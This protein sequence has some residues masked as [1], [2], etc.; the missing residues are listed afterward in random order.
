MSPQHRPSATSLD[1]RL[2]AAFAKVPVVA[3][4]VGAPHLKDFLT[5]PASVCILASIPVGKLPQVV[6]ALGRAGK[7]VFVNVDSSPGLAQDRGALE[8]LR[9][10]GAAGMVSTRLSLVEKG[11]PLGLLTMQKVFVT[12]RS[13]LNRSLDA[14]SRGLPDLVEVMPAPIVARMSAE[15]LRALTPHVA[16]GFVQSAADVAEAL[17]LGAVAAATSDPRLWHLTRDALAEAAEK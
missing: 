1:R 17:E 6:P 7:T 3:S 16:A 11:R 12:D 13:N 15:S 4:V 2:S 5:A 14:V 8:F 10:L 9:Q